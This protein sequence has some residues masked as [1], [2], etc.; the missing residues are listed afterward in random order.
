MKNTSSNNIE[1]EAETPISLEYIK[2]EQERRRNDDDDSI[3]QE[4]FYHILWKKNND[5]EKRTFKV[6]AA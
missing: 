1:E 3:P 2:L 4:H 5:D 6:K